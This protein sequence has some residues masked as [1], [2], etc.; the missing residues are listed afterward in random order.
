MEHTIKLQSALKKMERR[1]AGD[2]QTRSFEKS[3]ND[4]NDMVRSGVIKSRGYNILSVENSY[5]TT[6]LE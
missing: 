5:L 2:Q 3:M 6:Q 1:F 4:F